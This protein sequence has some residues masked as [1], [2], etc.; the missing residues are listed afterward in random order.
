MIT[1]EPAMSALST[2]SDPSESLSS[3]AAGWDANR[4]EEEF[5]HSKV[6][7]VSTPPRAQEGFEGEEW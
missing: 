6:A 1:R 2:I 4:D 7:P 3:T 5:Q